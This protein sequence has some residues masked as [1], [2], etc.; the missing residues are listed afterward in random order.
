MRQRKVLKE[1]SNIAF[2]NEL[3]VPEVELGQLFWTDVL[4]MV[5]QTIALSMSA[6]NDELMDL[7]SWFFSSE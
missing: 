4:N 3:D 1:S 2:K 7:F 6:G 5:M